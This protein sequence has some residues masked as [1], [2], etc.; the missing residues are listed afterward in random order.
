M[1]EISTINF[2]LDNLTTL[3]LEHRRAEI[4]KQINTYPMGSDDPEVPLS[5]LHELLAVTNRLRR[6]HAG[7]PKPTKTQ[8]ERAAKPTKRA[9]LEDLEADLG[10]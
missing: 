6:G 1:P 8:K 2:D 9:S 7:P 3:D 10:L 5:L 4:V